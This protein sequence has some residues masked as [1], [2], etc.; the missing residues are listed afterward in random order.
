MKAVLDTNVFISGIHW[1]GAS[2]KILFAWFDNKFD[3][4]C[5]E[6]IIEEIAQVLVNF[7]IPLSFE[8]ILWWIGIIAEK[9]VLVEPTEKFEIIT[10]CPADNKFLEAAISGNAEYIVTQ[11]K[12]LLNLKEFRNTKIIE[13]KDF[14]SVFIKCRPDDKPHTG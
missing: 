5:S 12:H 11:D 9:S 2:E 6:P 14:L 10:R 4:I 1:S 13:P 7:K 3:L 8:D